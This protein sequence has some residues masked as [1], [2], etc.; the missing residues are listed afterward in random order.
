VHQILGSKPERKGPLGSFRLRR[1]NGSKHELKDVNRFG[2]CGLNA[3]DSNLGELAISCKDGNG[4]VGAIICEEFVHYLT[5]ISL[6]TNTLIR[7]VSL[8][9]FKISK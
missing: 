5:T 7:G 3:S 6:S 1:D 4:L 8:R 2:G 9:K